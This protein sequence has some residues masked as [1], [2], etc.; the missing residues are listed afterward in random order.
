MPEPEF[1]PFPR[2]PPELRIQIWKLAFRPLSGYTGGVYYSTMPPM[3]AKTIARKF[4]PRPRIGGANAQHEYLLSSCRSSH[5]WDISLVDV[6]RESRAVVRGIARS[7]RRSPGQAKL[8]VPRQLILHEGW[9]QIYTMYQPKRDLIIVTSRYQS[10]DVLLRGEHLEDFVR[11]VILLRSPYFAG[12]MSMIDLG[13]EYEPHCPS[14]QFEGWERGS[15]RTVILV[16]L[17]RFTAQMLQHPVFRLWVIERSS[18]ICFHNAEGNLQTTN[19]TCQRQIQ[20]PRVIFYDLD[21]EYVSVEPR[22]YD[23]FRGCLW[24]T[25]KDKSASMYLHL[26]RRTLVTDRERQIFDDSVGI[27]S[28]RPFGG[29]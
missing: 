11:R 8:D 10:R 17:I 28:C 14:P 4:P 23:N 5:R 25:C 7:L 19:D 2:L 12:P 1:H 24:H 3:P 20:E 22:G 29:S 18:V 16:E 13:F 15:R 27:L 6:C 9:R 26:C 21:M